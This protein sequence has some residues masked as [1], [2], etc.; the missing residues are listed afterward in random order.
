MKTIFYSLFILLV[1]FCTLQSTLT[2]AQT[3]HGIF[4]DK[5]LLEEYSKQYAN[6]PKNVLLAMV[7]DETLSQYKTAAAVR[8][9]RE[10]FA[11]VIFSR[12]KKLAIRSLIRRLS[13]TDSIF[14]EIEIMYTL[15]EMDRYKYFKSMV[16]NLIRD[17][18]HYN[19]TA[20][21][22]SFTYINNI[23][24]SGQ[25]RAREAR[26]IFNTLRKILFLSRKKIRNITEPNERL[27][28][29]IELLRWSIKILGNQ[30]LKRLPPETLH[31]F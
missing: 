27:K 15:C 20:N 11:Q 31:L 14:V 28:Q 22:L 8:I 26:I 3:Q 29:K 6:E 5:N 24:S 18:D 1:S 13:R 25:N 4:N 12:E 19:T 21:E 23:I 30:E 2:Y 9:F 17:L 10:K 7:D 16:P